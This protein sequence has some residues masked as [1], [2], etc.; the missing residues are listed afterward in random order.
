M[1]KIFIGSSKEIGKKCIEWAIN[2][3]PDQFTLVN[4]PNESDIFISVLYDKIL[5]HDFISQ[6]L[7]YNFHPGILPKYRGVGIFS[8]VLLNGED[9]TGTTLHLIDK[10]IDTGDIIEIRD[11]PITEKDTAYSLYKKGM[12]ITFKMFKDWY[13]DL[14]KLN[15]TTTTQTKKYKIYTQKD[16]EERKNITKLV[17]AFCFPGKESLYYINGNGKKLFLDL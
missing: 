9:K 4:D 14:L 6:R 16:L 1:K 8:W 10:G 7:C 5:S 15:Y 2:N 17:K 13:V 12:D 11:F 3:T